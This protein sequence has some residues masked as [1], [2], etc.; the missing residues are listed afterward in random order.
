MSLF[1]PPALQSIYGSVLSTVTLYPSQP[2][3]INAIAVTDGIGGSYF[4]PLADIV[5][6]VSFSTISTTQLTAST[7]LLK[8]NTSN[9]LLYAQGGQLFLNG[10][11][12]GSGSNLTLSN[13]S[14]ADTISSIST[15]TEFL[16]APQ[17]LT[18]TIS[19]TFDVNLHSGGN[20]VTI[21]NGAGN[22]SQQ[23]YSVAIGY[24]A[25][26]IN[27]QSNTIA[28]GRQTGHSNQGDY[29]IAIGA[30]A[31]SDKNDNVSQHDSTIVLN[32]TGDYFMTSAPKGF[33]VKPIRNAPAATVL[34]YE[35]SSGEI[36]YNTGG[37]G[38]VDSNIG[39]S[40]VQILDTLSTTSTFTDFLSASQLLTSSITFNDE[41]RIQTANVSGSGQPSI[42]IGYGAG[43][44]QNIGSVAIGMGAGSNAQSDYSISI[45][46]NAGNDTQGNASVAIGV[47]AG[48]SLQGQ[49]SVA[50][51][52]YAAVTR[53]GEFAIAIGDNAGA[54]YQSTNAIAIGTEAGRWYQTSNTVALGFKAGW[55]NQGLSAVAI[56]CNA[57]YSNQQ[58]NSVAIGRFAGYANQESGSIAL[59]YYSGAGY[60]QNNTV[61]IGNQA[62]RLNQ[63][64]GAI[65]IGFQAGFQGQGINSIAIGTNA[66]NG[67]NS[68]SQHDST[69]VLN[70]TG[71]YLSTIGPSSFYVAPIR[72]DATPNLST[73][74]YNPYTKEITYGPPS[75]GS[76][77][78]NY[79]FSNLRVMD[80]L[81]TTSTFTDFI[82]T[83][84][85]F[86]QYI[87]TYSMT[88]FGSNTLTVQGN[89]IMSTIIMTGQIST[90]GTAPFATDLTLQ[91][92]TLQDPAT[93]ANQTMFTSTI[94][95]QTIVETFGYTT[96]TIKSF[97]VPKGV[98]SVTAQVWGAGG[99]Q[100]NATDG[101]GNGAYIR[102][103]FSVTP[104]ETLD[105]IVGQN[106]AAGRGAYGGGGLNG[107][108]GASWIK[109]GGTV[110]LLAGAGGSG[111][112][113]GFNGGSA[114]VGSSSGLN[115]GGGTGNGGEG[116]SIIQGGVGGTGD[117]PG[118]EGGPI[119]V[120]DPTIASGGSSGY[121]DSGGGGG[122]GWYGGGGGGLDGGP[123]T[124]GGGGGS[125]YTDVSVTVLTEIGGVPAGTTP[126]FVSEPN[127]AN[128]VGLGG[129]NSVSPAGA[130]FITITYTQQIPAI[131]SQNQF[132]SSL[133]SDYV[134]T[135]AVYAGAG[136][137]GPFD[138]SDPNKAKITGLTTSAGIN[139][140]VYYNPTDGQLNYNTLGAGSD[141]IAI[142]N[143]AGN[144]LQ[145]LNA[146]AIGTNAGSTSQ[147]VDAIAIGY[148]AGGASQ[149][150][151][152]IAIGYQAG[153]ESQKEYSIAI[154]YQA[155]M[156]NQAQNTIILNATG[157]DING[158][159]AQTDSFYVAPIRPD[160]TA[161]L[162]TLTYNP[163]TKEV[164]FGNPVNNIQF[165]SVQPGEFTSGFAMLTFPTSFS[166]P[167]YVI[168]TASSGY[169]VLVTTSNLTTSQVG[170]YQQEW[171]GTTFV[172]SANEIAWIAIGR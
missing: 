18:S 137:V 46:Y 4:V 84:A 87:S 8:D 42:M 95:E 145:G 162:S 74:S 41:I 146:V 55:S 97:V 103:S 153:L 155:G 13:L 170:I 48:N 40:N 65:A 51:G 163:Y 116:G 3:P 61:A 92:L 139:T 24:E 132:V 122:A 113:D 78:S 82:S 76:I 21:G 154:G 31:G 138:G 90:V 6:E 52:N 120:A 32:A 56:G 14:V 66:G 62:G 107:G 29:S 98:T 5:P 60:Q 7:I 81:S 160:A 105:I 64:T 20:T 83:N 123:S 43:L 16:S 17:I 63:S 150:D 27:Q 112:L 165:G 58:T 109:R 171:D 86:A 102:G 121:N 169:N 38:S 108:G 104:E 152:S 124:G 118:Q 142:G 164:T 2:P 100:F 157:S 47:S 117:L 72:S 22:N 80:T 134:S 57:G 67:P 158:V 88:V 1:P 151:Y 91:S 36:T 39:F 148:S 168:T 131:F 115:G 99:A 15:F 149:K 33:Y 53:Q 129:T 156:D 140:V 71:D 136:I 19:F 25:G 159:G 30:F 119:T 135:M 167:P 144:T 161:N 106:G 94:M 125:S 23:N 96:N 126:A 101:G 34:F 70:A 85:I 141:G 127:W 73:L 44:S 79:A 49:N 89:T 59:G 9:S 166:S 93:K 54:L 28:I 69:I 68:E 45:G 133:T 111:S 10:G 26:Y 110:L 50:V 77:D 12:I 35:A 114:G 128:N 11:P 75:G 147:G 130:G 172:A 37:G 143:S